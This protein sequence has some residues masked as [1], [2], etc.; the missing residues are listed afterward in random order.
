MAKVIGQSRWT[1]AHACESERPSTAIVKNFQRRS[2]RYV[3]RPR[4]LGTGASASC[5]SLPPVTR[6]L[7]CERT[8]SV[9]VAATTPSATVQHS[10]A[11]SGR[12]GNASSS[13]ESAAASRRSPK[14]HSKSRPTQRVLRCRAGDLH[15]QRLN[16]TGGSLRSESEPQSGNF[17]IEDRSALKSA[18]EMNLCA[19]FHS[20]KYRLESPDSLTQKTVEQNIAARKREMQIS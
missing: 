1:V 6:G 5:I 7:K 19:G 20:L 11:I 8:P 13:S 4:G 3:W 18:R 14:N 2:D 9:T 10:R 15:R 16:V 12:T 17:E